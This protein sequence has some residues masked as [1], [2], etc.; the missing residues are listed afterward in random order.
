MHNFIS[1]FFIHF[2]KNSST[3]PEY[4]T[5]Y[6]A[7]SCSKK[8]TKLKQRKHVDVG[9]CDNCIATTLSRQ[10]KTWYI[11]SMPQSWHKDTGSV[12]WHLDH[13]TKTNTASLPLS[14]ITI[15]ILL[16]WKRWKSFIGNNLKTRGKL[17]SA[18]DTYQLRKICPT[19]HP[20][21]RTIH[22]KCK[23]YCHS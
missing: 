16:R 3:W 8:C 22:S 13:R 18:S 10:S 21:V 4:D 6:T 14:K 11:L 2:F 19:K 5:E 7:A 12:R 17:S 23:M 20:L 1:E 9:C 15:N